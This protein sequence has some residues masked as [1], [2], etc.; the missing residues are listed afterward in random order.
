MFG[1]EL[2]RTR[3]NG[4]EDGYREQNR[5][6]ER[7]NKEVKEKG[8]RASDLAARKSSSESV[9]GWAEV[10]GDAMQRSK[11][12]VWVGRDEWPLDFELSCH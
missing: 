1:S 9:D 11:K 2:S 6:K 5:K 12:Q 4:G 10:S 8:R 3:N 7:K